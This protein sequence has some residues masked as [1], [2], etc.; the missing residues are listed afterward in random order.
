MFPYSPILIGFIHCVTSAEHCP[1]ANG[2]KPFYLCLSLPQWALHSLHVIDHSDIPGF[3]VCC[4]RHGLMRHWV[5]GLCLLRR[6]RSSLAFLPDFVRQMLVFLRAPSIESSG[7]FPG[8]S[9]SQLRD[10]SCIHH[11][12][13]CAMATEKASSWKSVGCSKCVSGHSKKTSGKHCNHCSTTQ[14]MVY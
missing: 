3:T 4:C 13:V 7:S 11:C 2:S 14:H 5:T 9:Q 10:T 6:E 1:S 12:R 8:S